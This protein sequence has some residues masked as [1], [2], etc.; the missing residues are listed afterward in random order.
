MTWVEKFR[1]PFATQ[2]HKNA[3]ISV[4]ERDYTGTLQVL[5]AGDTPFETSEDSDEDVFKPVRSQTG[6]LRVSQ[7][8]GNEN[9]KDLIEKIMP[10][11]NTSNLIRLTIDNVLQWQGFLQANMFTQSWNDVT[12]IIE[13]PTISI[14]GALEYINIPEQIA[15][16]YKPFAWYLYNGLQE[17]GD[18]YFFTEIHLIDDAATINASWFC[19][20]VSSMLFFEQEQVQNVGTTITVLQGKN[21][22][23]VLEQTLQLFGLTIREQATKLYI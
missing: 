20:R 6:T 10:T 15:G 19:Q 16:I 8:Y 5:T 23:E 18:S 12:K 9:E 4:F 3:V 2:S 22:R 11:T 1:I 14:L 17:L 7:H 21:Y 13:I